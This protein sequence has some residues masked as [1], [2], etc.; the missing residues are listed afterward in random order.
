M[1]GQFGRLIAI[2]DIHGCVH[3]LDV[4]LAEIVPSSSDRLVFLGD[5]IDQGRDSGAVIDRLL[6]LQQQCD[7]V[8]AR[9]KVPFVTGK[10]VE[11]SRR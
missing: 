7:V 9:V 2:G 3:A 5:L 11:V 6:Q 1:S 4:L 10:I 8:R